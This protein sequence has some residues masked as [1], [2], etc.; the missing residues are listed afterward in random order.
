MYLFFVYLMLLRSSST[1]FWFP[2]RLSS[3][4]GNREKCHCVSMVL[5]HI[6]LHITDPIIIAVI[7]P[8]YM[9]LFWFHFYIVRVF[10]TNTGHL[11][12]A[13]TRSVSTGYSKKGAPPRCLSHVGMIMTRLIARLLNV[14][15]RFLLSL[16]IPR[17]SK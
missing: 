14:I 11:S 9:V 7:L 12:T 13:F 10:I 17:A 2:Q 6:F 8:S 15:Y 3:G 1:E 5:R 16:E 4:Y